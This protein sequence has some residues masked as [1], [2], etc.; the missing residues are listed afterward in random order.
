MK[1]TPISYGASVRGPMHRREGKPNQDAWL[2]TS[3]R[4][5]SLVVVC[6]GMGSKLNARMGARAACAATREAVVRWSKVDGAPVSYLAHLVEVLWRL[7]VH[8]GD[9]SDAA[10]TCLLA[11]VGASGQWVVGGVGD[12][13]VATRTGDEPVIRFMGDRDSNFGSET[14]ALGVSHG[15]KA[16]KLTVLPPTESDRLVVLATDGAADDLIPEKLD[17]FCN[18]L[19]DE[20]LD[21][22]PPKRWRQ[23]QTELRNWPTPRHIDDK[24]VALLRVP[25]MAAEEMA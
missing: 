17:A 10:T 24:T 1:R 25:A 15:P 7:R 18:W 19:V 9:P 4:F 13:L 16:W 23:L 3:G 20:F 21:I 8:P 6:D 14:S 5:G 12:G 2:R 11:F 22:A